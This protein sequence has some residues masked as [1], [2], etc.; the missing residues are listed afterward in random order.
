M[1]RQ[2]AP[3]LLIMWESHQRGGSKGTSS[4]AG[5]L[6]ALFFLMAEVSLTLDSIQE[7]SADV[8]TDL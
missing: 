2:P 5:H 4:A 8:G 1:H 3:H 7:V 6:I